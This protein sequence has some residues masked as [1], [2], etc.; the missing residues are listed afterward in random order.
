[1]VTSGIRLG[2]PAVTTRGFGKE[3]MKLIAALIVRVISSPDDQKIWNE[4][5]QEVAEMCR[6]FPVPGID[7]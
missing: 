2:T 1:M 4:V 7:D 6:R 3:E 5:E